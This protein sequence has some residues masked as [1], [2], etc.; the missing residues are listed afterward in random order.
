MGQMLRLVFKFVSRVVQR[1]R[2][3]RLISPTSSVTQMYF[4]FK[5][6][7]KNSVDRI[8]IKKSAHSLLM[9]WMQ[10]IRLHQ[11]RLRNKLD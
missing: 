8:I 5:H 4:A 11:T 3:F 2:F 10:K 9:V 1:L 6:L 7:K